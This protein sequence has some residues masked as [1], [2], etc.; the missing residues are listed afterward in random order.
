[1]NGKHTAHVLNTADESYFFPEWLPTFST[2]LS[3]HPQFNYFLRKAFSCF[4]YPVSY[5]RSQPPVIIIYNTLCTHQQAS[6][7]S[8][9]DST[10]RLLIGEGTWPILST[11]VSPLAITSLAQSSCSISINSSI[12]TVKLKTIEQN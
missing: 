12:L 2:V 8:M 4:S 7:C 11:T 5:T 9:S 1:M 10:I 3:N 6:S